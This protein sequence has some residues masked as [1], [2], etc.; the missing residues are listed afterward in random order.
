MWIPFVVFGRIPPGPATF[1]D[2]RLMQG[3]ESILIG[4]P[5][6]AIYT[7]KI[8]DYFPRVPSRVAHSA[9][10]L[11]HPP[12]LDPGISARRSMRRRALVLRAGNSELHPMN[13]S[14]RLDAGREKRVR[15][16]R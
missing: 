4:P 14:A 15:T 12:Q 3:C 5:E 7:A 8:P 11:L 2:A 13:R 9:I 6:K 1:S 16:S 10:G